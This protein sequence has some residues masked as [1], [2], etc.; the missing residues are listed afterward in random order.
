MDI[1]TVSLCAQALLAVFLG[2]FLYQARMICLEKNGYVHMH[3][4]SEMD[5]MRERLEAILMSSR[6]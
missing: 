3:R 5:R 6:S 4:R 2:T 1:T